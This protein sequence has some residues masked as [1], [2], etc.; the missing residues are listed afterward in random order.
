MRWVLGLLTLV[1]IATVGVVVWPRRAESPAAVV[2]DAGPR[3][4]AG[5]SAS[6]SPAR[7]PPRS[8]PVRPPTRSPGPPS[9]VRGDVPAAPAPA[10][11]AAAE[12]TTPLD[13]GV[14]MTAE[15]KKLH[16]LRAAKWLLR[17]ERY[18]KAAE[19]GRELVAQYP[20]MINAYHVAVP[21]LC[22]I[23]EA[24][25]ALAYFARVTR[26]R[27]RRMIAEKCADLGMTLQP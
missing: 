8:V 2:P 6:P 7:T 16:D 11:P 17:H 18:E 5:S 4:E 3:A 22:A 24:E 12:T 26:D 25:E 27:N 15:E 23:G 20:D 21:A 10:A 14:P 13:A 1:I 19:A 9:P